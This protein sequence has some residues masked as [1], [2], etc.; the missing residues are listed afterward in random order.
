MVDKQPIHVQNDLFK[1][2]LRQVH[3]F[4]PNSSK[5]AFYKLSI[6]FEFNRYIIYKQS[7][8]GSKILDTRKWTFFL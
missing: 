2:I 8:I 1:H 3:L 7:G 6:G 5:K 4:A